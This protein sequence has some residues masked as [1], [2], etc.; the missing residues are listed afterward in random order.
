MRMLLYALLVR[1]IA[2]S[3]THSWKDERG[4]REQFDGYLTDL[5]FQIRAVPR[6][7][8]CFLVAFLLLTLGEMGAREVHRL[9]H[10]VVTAAAD[11]PQRADPG[12]LFLSASG[13]VQSYDEQIASLKAPNA[14]FDH[15]GITVCAVQV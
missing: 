15:L 6:D 4:R 7:G 11:Y 8:N 9:R 2:L 13:A 10:A 12:F 3:C 14:W 1:V 5:G